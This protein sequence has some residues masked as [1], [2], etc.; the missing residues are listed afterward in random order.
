MENGQTQVSVFVLS[1]TFNV[2]GKLLFYRI[3]TRYYVS[4]KDNVMKL[5]SLSLMVAQNKLG[6]LSRK[7]FKLL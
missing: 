6:C 3:E 7:C 4:T 1:V 2:L 5:F